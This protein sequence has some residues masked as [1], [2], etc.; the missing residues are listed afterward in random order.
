M[1]HK[2]T[3]QFLSMSLLFSMMA[4]SAT[5]AQTS[6]SEMVENPFALTDEALASAV[7]P[8]NGPGT[9]PTASYTDP[10]VTAQLPDFQPAPA[11]STPDSALNAEIARHKPTAGWAACSPAR[12]KLTA[13][14]GMYHYK[15]YQ[16]LLT[17]A[18]NMQG[19]QTCSTG[20]CTQYNTEVTRR[21]T[22]TQNIHIK[23]I[24]F[25]TTFYNIINQYITIIN[26]PPNN[27][28]NNTNP[29]NYT[30]TNYGPTNYGPNNYG[31]T[32]YGPN[33]P[34]PNGYTPTNYGP[35]NYGPNNYGP[36]NYGPSNYGPTNYGPTNYG[37]T[38]YGPTNYGPSNI[39][40]TNYG[41]TNYGPTNYGPSN[42]GP[43]NFGPSNFGPSNFGPSNFGPTNFGP[44]N[45]GP[46]NFGP[47]N[48]GPT[49]F[50]PNNFGPTN[51]GPSN[52]GPSNIGPT[53]YAPT[54]YGPN[55]YGPN[56]YG[57]TNYGPSNY[58][59]SNYGPNN[60]GPGNYG[61]NN[62][63]PGNY[64]PNN[65]GVNNYGVNNYG[66]TYYGPSNVG[67]NNYAPNNYG[68]NNY[69]PG[70]YGPTNYGPSNYGP[71]NPGPSNGGD[72]CVIKL[73]LPSDPIF[74]TKRIVDVQLV[75]PKG[76]LLASYFKPP[77][78]VSPGVIH[79]I[80]IP[81]KCQ[82]NQVIVI[83]LNAIKNC[84]TLLIDLSPYIIKVIRR[85]VIIFV[86]YITWGDPHINGKVDI[87]YQNAGK[88]DIAISTRKFQLNTRHDAFGS[89]ASYIGQTALRT[90]H[91]GEN[92]TFVF[93]ASG[94]TVDGQAAQVSTVSGTKIK[95]YKVGKSGVKY[96]WKPD[97]KSF[98]IL[99]PEGNL[100]QQIAGGMVVNT[101]YSPTTP[102]DPTMDGWLG[103]TQ[104][105]RLPNPATGAYPSTG[106]GV[107]AGNDYGPICQNQYTCVSAYDLHDTTLPGGVMDF[108]S[109]PGGHNR[110]VNKSPIGPWGVDGTPFS[111]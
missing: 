111:E 45:F 61:P 96:F 55:N 37:P 95:V 29:N 91:G 81:G 54:N 43:N 65:Y 52:F 50:G 58:G 70:N 105:N 36:S 22:Y 74:V 4:S 97:S 8:A 44:S 26:N 39:G 100:Q 66:P 18:R 9:N 33:N 62:Y 46:T 11:I 84:K 73:R 86:P 3:V 79:L 21:G 40:P 25:L 14:Y 80:P 68:P 85:R 34:S 28:P 72:P 7:E 104:I 109:N 57:P 98:H 106:K 32:N 92:H 71:N 35:T 108:T 47:N 94:A 82:F 51:F 69:G 20:E 10:F 6:G 64:G 101:S 78:L 12:K 99:M 56:N 15:N 53:N 1:L 88:S 87:N 90:T 38:N 75:F 60:Y 83:D 2:K 102:P 24:T 77:V 16:K 110:M 59:P 67:P 107:T 89:S 31:P 76:I 48:F 49:N 5:I 42:F 30:P 19:S 103:H 17:E 93:S 63:G 41:P 23:N 13:W 27:S